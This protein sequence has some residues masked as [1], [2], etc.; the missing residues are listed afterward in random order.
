MTRISLWLIRIYQFTL[1]PIF[2]VMSAC[3]YQPTCSW[4]TT[5]AI[6][7]FG[8]RRGWWL[9]IRRIGRCHPGYTGGQDPVPEA[10]LTWREAR[11]RHQA[12]RAARSA[13]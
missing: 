7:R 13:V 8:A 9:G 4:Y 2:G 5:G 3:R 11:R 10:Y 1:G 12:E 6:S